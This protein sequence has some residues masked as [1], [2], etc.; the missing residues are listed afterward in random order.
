M[1]NPVSPAPADERD[2]H[3]AGFLTFV[4]RPKAGAG[5][6]IAKLDRLGV[7]VKIITGPTE[8]R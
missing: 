6:A 8:P 2:L 4:D 3:L 5:A 7:A 1:S